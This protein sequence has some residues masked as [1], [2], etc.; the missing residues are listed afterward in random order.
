MTDTARSRSDVDFD[1]PSSEH[2]TGCGALAGHRVGARS[3]GGQRGAGGITGAGTGRGSARLKPRFG[4]VEEP[5]D[6]R[7]GEAVARERDSTVLAHAPA[8]VGVVQGARVRDHG[9]P[10][11]PVV[12]RHVLLG[13]A[14]VAQ[15]SRYGRARRRARRPE[16]AGDVAREHHAPAVEREAPLGGQRRVSASRRGHA[17]ADLEA[18]GARDRL[19]GRAVALVLDEP[20][21]VGA[22]RDGLRR[23]RRRF[24]CGPELR[25][26]HPGHVV[27][28]PDPPERR[29]HD[30][31][32]ER[33]YAHP[34]GGVRN[35]P[36]E[37][38]FV[39]AMH[40]R[41]PASRRVRLDCVEPPLGV[42][43]REQAPDAALAPAARITAV[44]PDRTV[45]DPGHV[46]AGSGAERLELRRAD[47]DRDVRGVRVRERLARLQRRRGGEAEAGRVPRV[48]RAPHAAPVHPDARALA[49]TGTLLVQGEDGGALSEGRPVVDRGTTLAGRER[50]GRRER[51]AGERLCDR[52]GLSEAADLREVPGGGVTAAVGVDSRRG[53]GSCAGLGR[54]TCAM[55]R[56]PS[57]GSRSGRRR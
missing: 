16:R 15:S 30:R 27:L 23:E 9:D 37:R 19:L 24:G 55:R 41:L 17:G 13:V 33:G 6:L 40:A 51:R 46:G 1:G 42:G 36:E 52:G 31:G 5:E 12:V 4:A 34:I 35:P 3:G 32:G 56:L 7:P 28:E 26:R 38:P 39:E 54:G 18:L 45:A 57:P 22:S 8:A 29:D 11:E 21:H 25:R 50:P 47:D 48:A 20:H 44:A 10:S 43:A 53:R 2:A 49:H 14:R